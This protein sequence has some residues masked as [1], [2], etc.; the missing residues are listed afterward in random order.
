MK[1]MLIIVLMIFSV[2]SHAFNWKK[3][4]KNYTGHWFPAMFTLVGSSS[5][6]ISSTGDCSAFAMVQENKKKL[7]VAQ[8]LD[9]LQIDIARGQGEYLDAYAA[10]S[11][12]HKSEYFNKILQSN[13]KTIFGEN[14]DSSPHE[15]YEATN[16]LIELSTELKGT[17]FLI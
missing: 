11:G 13:Y 8:N 16:E 15:V 3:C 9:N 4:R 10:L 14:I 17:C 1:I 5:S 7:Y 12:C 6:Y 2:Q